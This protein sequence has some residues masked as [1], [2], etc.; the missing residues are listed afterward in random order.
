VAYVDEITPPAWKAT[1]M[2]L[3]NAALSLGSLLSGML[4]GWLLDYVGGGK[5]YLINAGLLL[6]AALFLWQARLRKDP[7]QMQ[8]A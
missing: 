4:N 7:V 6:V 1:S 8:P 5:M 2:G 3:F